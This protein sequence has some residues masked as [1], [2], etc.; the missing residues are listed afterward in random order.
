MAAV[1]KGKILLR[2]SIVSL[3]FNVTLTMVLVTYYG[4][5][6]AIVA[7][8]ITLYC[9][10][11]FIS[12]RELSLSLKCKF[13]E[14][15]PYRN[16]AKIMFTALISAIPTY[17]IFGFLNSLNEFIQLVIIGL[18]YFPLYLF[19]GIKYKLFSQD[20]LSYIRINSNNL[21]LKLLSYYKF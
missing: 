21:K 1:G 2:N 4:Y 11:V 19:I 16:L 6:G 10:D 9:W 12:L 13:I 20:V 17:F 14:V 3:C 15:Y 7:T 8:I 5:L 18:V